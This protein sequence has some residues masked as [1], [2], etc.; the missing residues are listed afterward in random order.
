[1]QFGPWRILDAVDR[2]EDLRQAGQFDLLAWA[3]TRVIGGKAAVLAGCQS[4]VA[5]TRSNAGRKRLM[6]STA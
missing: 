2:P 4:C 6:T 1:M 5:T 3:V